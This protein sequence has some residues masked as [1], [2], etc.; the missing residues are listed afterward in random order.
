MA[1]DERK[2]D[3]NMAMMNGIILGAIGVLVLI[4]PLATSISGTGLVMDLVAG[5]TLTLGG[6]VSYLRGRSRSRAAS[7]P[8]VSSDQPNP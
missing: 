2:S 8:D 6:L 5:G 7:S 3:L 4:T 1:N